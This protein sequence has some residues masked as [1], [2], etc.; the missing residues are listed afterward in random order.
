MPYCHYKLIRK[1]FSEAE[2]YDTN[3]HVRLTY[4]FREPRVS[5]KYLCC[6]AFPMSLVLAFH[7]SNS[8]YFLDFIVTKAFWRIFFNSPNLENIFE[9]V[10]ILKEKNNENN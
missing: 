3:L 10:A 2:Y 9:K 1:Y 7:P 6:Q 5:E 4:Y 8:I